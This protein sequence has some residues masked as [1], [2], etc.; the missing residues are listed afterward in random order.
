MY[1]QAKNKLCMY[2]VQVVQETRIPWAH[3][4]YIFVEK[5]ESF[6]K[7]GGYRLINDFFSQGDFLTHLL[8]KKYKTWI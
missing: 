3:I 7:I 4:I 5:F 8:E 2:S 6:T 1:V